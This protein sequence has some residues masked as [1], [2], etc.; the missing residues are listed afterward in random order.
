MTFALFQGLNSLDEDDPNVLLA[1]QLSLQESGLVMDGETQEIL[2]NEA[3]M[4]AIGTSLP[5]RLDPVLPSVELPRGAL[6][7]S[8]LL[9]LGDSLMRL[10]NITSQYTPEPFDNLHPFDP[11]LDMQR[12]PAMQDNVD[13]GGL[14]SQ[15]GDDAVGLTQ[16]ELEGMATVG[17]LNTEP[18]NRQVDCNADPSHPDVPECESLP[19][20][21]PHSPEWEEQVHL[22]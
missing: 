13:G 4:G 9:E 21:Q 18:D 5:S 3:S 2:N 14:S 10:G 19:D 15:T 20:L 22:V 17:V 12:D 16:L 8:E 6:S 11:L 7:S 1:I